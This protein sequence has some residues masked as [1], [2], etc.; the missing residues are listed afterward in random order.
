M[1]SGSC[2]VTRWPPRTSFSAPSSASR[3]TR[4]SASTRCSTETNSSSSVRASSNASSSAFRKRSA[5]LRLRVRA[6]DGRQRSQA[7]LGFGPDR[8]GIGARALQ[9]RPRQ[10]LLEQR[11]GEVVAGQLR[12]AGA[13][14]QLL[15]A[16]DGLAGLDRQLVEVHRSSPSGMRSA[17]RCAAAAGGTGRPRAGTA[18]GSRGS[19]D[20]AWPRAAPSARAGAAARPRAAARARRRPG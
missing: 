8:A 10:L 12:V 14:R 11:H 2:V 13:A 1:P 15:C 9:Q 6:R 19:R 20:G 4:S 18:G 7:R 17:L 5:R 16:G 3:G